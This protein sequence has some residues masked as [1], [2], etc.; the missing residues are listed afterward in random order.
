MSTERLLSLLLRWVLLS[1]CVWVAAELIS[2]IRYDGWQSIA[3]VALILGLLNLY[4]RPAVTLLTLPLTVL[5]LGLFLLVVNAAFFLLASWIAGQLDVSFHV[6]DFWAALLGA[7]IM[8]VVGL[9]VGMFVDPD[10]I[11]RDLSGG[12]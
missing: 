7:I 2:G 9:I 1:F 8:S 5:T 11:A 10:R 3:I 12:R 6:D 4:V